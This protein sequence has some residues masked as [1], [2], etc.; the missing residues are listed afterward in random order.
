[1]TDYLHYQ[2]DFTDPLEFLKLS[3]GHDLIK[4]QICKQQTLLS[5]IDIDIHVNEQLQ[6]LTDKTIRHLNFEDKN[7][8]KQVTIN[9]VQSAVENKKASS[10]Y[11]RRLFKQYEADSYEGGLG[12]FGVSKIP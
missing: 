8:E 9:K 7:N 11:R 10:S 12:N 4:L 1:M 5:E 6:I 3:Q 2:M